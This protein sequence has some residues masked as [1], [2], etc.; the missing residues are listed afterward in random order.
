MA[1]SSLLLCSSSSLSLIHFLPIFSSIS[2]SFSLFFLSISSSSAFFFS[3]SSFSLCFSR[4]SLASLSSFSLMAS[5]SLLLCSSSSLSLIHFLRLSSCLSSFL[6]SSLIFLSSATSTLNSAIFFSKTFFL[7]LRR[8]S[9]YLSLSSLIRTIL[10]L[11]STSLARCFFSPSILSF[12]C[13]SH[14]TLASSLNS[15]NCNLRRGI[16]SSLFAL[17]RWSTFFSW[18][19]KRTCNSFFSFSSSSTCLAMISSASI[20]AI[21]SA[22]MPSRTFCPISV[23]A[24]WAILSLVCLAWISL[25]SFSFL[26]L[27]RS[28][29]SICNLLAS[30]NFCFSISFLLL[31]IAAS[32]CAL[33][34]F[35][36]H[37]FLSSMILCRAR[38]RWWSR[39]LLWW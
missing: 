20:F 24:N 16:S 7:S 27:S 3:Y 8:L 11:F 18:A 19:F 33:L 37:S 17:S 30:S 26:C 23:F 14:T 31:S 25:I 1:S 13:S 39:T 10:S 15:S 38:R 35:S 9:R 32:C 21:S 4:A 5:S 22:F 2:R 29:L 12:S 28:S 6:R 36:S 34:Y